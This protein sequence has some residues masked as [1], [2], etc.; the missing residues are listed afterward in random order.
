MDCQDWETVVVRSRKTGIKTQQEKRE[1]AQKQAG[2]HM[3]KLETAD[4]LKPKKKRLTADSRQ[5]LV[6]A[7]V[8]I[9][10]TQREVDAMC[11]FPP[12]TMR[13]FEAGT[14]APTG[15][16]ISQLQREFAAAKLVLRVETV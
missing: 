7:R 11:A 16:Q 14:V 3:Y 10:K 12:N 2:Y 15:G 13:D 9:K 8:A 1:I 6:A 5:A 4:D